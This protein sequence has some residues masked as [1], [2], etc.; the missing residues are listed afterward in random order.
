M[1]ALRTQ[2][3]LLL[4]TLTLMLLSSTGHSVIRDTDSHTPITTDTASSVHMK[5]YKAHLDLAKNMYRNT[6]ITTGNTKHISDSH[7]GNATYLS[8]VSSMCP[9]AI[10]F[11]RDQINSAMLPFNMTGVSEP[12]KGSTN[13]MYAQD[14][15]LG[16]VCKV[17]IF[18][19]PTTTL[20][21][22]V[23]YLLP[24]VAADDGSWG[25]FLTHGHVAINSDSR[26][27]LH[28]LVPV[29]YLDTKDYSLVYQN[30]PPLRIR[31]E[32]LQ[33]RLYIAKTSV[34]AG[35]VTMLHAEG[36][37][38]VCDQLKVPAG[39]VAIISFQR[40]PPEQCGI[41]V[42]LLC[43]D[44]HNSYRTVENFPGG[45][46]CVVKTCNGTQ[47][48][49][50]V[51][52]S[53]DYVSRESCF[54]LSFSFLPQGSLPETLSS[55][56]H[57]C[58]VADDT[59]RVDTGLCRGWVA[60]GQ[61][62]YKWFTSRD[63]YIKPEKARDLCRSM[64]FEL[65]LLKTMQGFQNFVKY[66]KPE[67]NIRSK[68]I[69]LVYK[70]DEIP[71]MYRHVLT[72]TDKTIIYNTNH[73]RMPKKRPLAKEYYY[74]SRQ[75]KDVLIVTTGAK[76]LKLKNF[77]CEKPVQLLKLS[78]SQSVE[79]PF[80][81]QSPL[82]SQQ[83]SQPVVLCTEGHVTLS[84]LSCDPKSRCGTTACSFALGT[85]SFSE[86]ISAALH[87]VD[88]VVMYAC[89]S[90]YREVSYSLLCDFRQ[91]CE[92][93]SDESF[94]YHP[95]C[96]GFSCPN[97][98]CLSL[99]KR[100]NK[101][102]DCLG[103]SDEDDCRLEQKWYDRDTTNQNQNTSYLI[104]FDGDG[105][106]T[107]RVMN[108][109]DPCPGTHYRCTKEWFYCLPVYTRCNGV[110]DCIF[111]EDERDCEGWTCPGLYRCRD[112]TVCVHADHMCDGWPVCPQH[113]DEWLCDMTCPT[114]CL[115][116]G[117]AFLC[118]QPFSAH[119]FPQLRYLDARGSGM[120]L[121][122]L[123]NN[124]YIVHLNLGHC[125][126]STLPAMTFPNLQFFDLSYNEI[127]SI[128]MN[129]FTALSNL[130]ILILK[131]NPLTSVTTNPSN[132]RQTLLRQIDLSE[133]HLSEFKSKMLP[134]SPGVKLL[135]IS[136]SITHSINTNL[137]L[138]VPFLREIDIRG[139]IVNDFPSDIFL[140]LKDLANVYSS[141]YR[142]CCEKIL[143]NIAPKP[144]CLAPKHYLSSC[145]DMLQSEVYR[146]NFWFVVVMASMTNLFC[147]ACH[148]VE[149][150]VQIPYTGPVVVFMASLLCADFCVGIYASVIAAAHETFS[151]QYVF[152]EDRWK[153]GVACKVAGFL[154]LLSREV[155]ILI[156][157]LLSL[158]HLT[159]V[160]F[161]ISTYRFSS[162]SAAV[163][164]GVTWIVGSLLA[165]VP[166]LPELS[167][168]AHYGHT[169]VCSLMLH[170]RRHL[171]YEHHFLHA[172]LIF[173]LFICLL[174]CVTLAIIY[175]ATP[176]NRVLIISSE[177]PGSTS[178]DV[179]MKI[180]VT[181]VAGWFSV[182]TASVLTLAGVTGIATNVFM[183]IMVLPLNAAVNPLLCLW[184]A[185]AYKR[186][187]KQEERL[188]RLLKSRR[189]CVSN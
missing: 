16:F 23:E 83:F 166:L 187:Q 11:Y 7:K 78:T 80:S 5:M 75:F 50:C 181:D 63:S 15:H 106:F 40:R 22:R 110:F 182:T 59:G 189:K 58:S 125:S 46:G 26:V 132:T 51:V 70:S 77:L 69:G 152:Y 14:K 109:T 56:R 21:A 143:P 120:A 47:L 76:Y 87:P 154:S 34:Y 156:I 12:P 3:F 121:F 140:G 43:S 88:H 185:V 114:Q 134:F 37:G 27:F 61:K 9:G 28:T 115:C 118:P 137:A 157:F 41:S 174:V 68:I 162:R 171:K 44:P 57:N 127:K 86:V 177:N 155:S 139:V 164:S 81:Q 108:I 173:N 136:Y 116:Q 1:D 147:L 17:V 145:D 188:L 149:T 66:L 45:Q 161:P 25:L 74:Y 64:G 167:H 105:F 71:S 151:G 10:E 42:S 13:W 112:S 35:F 18:V 60:A 159:L 135:N 148:C 146:F 133:T 8:E 95:T 111:Q 90:G 104:N 160:S 79:F 54:K 168:L 89:S 98:Q 158:N 102:V 180:A 122:Y 39:H 131:G 124:T 99:N 100:C 72:W 153:D 62:C 186:R 49:V 142:F 30:K 73:V 52:M 128:V 85:Q 178:V 107:Q 129:I 48:D 6:E 67:T 179:I 92:D 172:I 93:N 184:H 97:G 119:L 4:A 165:S 183:V 24:S 144:R 94:C 33:G 29:F 170:D 101:V 36:M 82:T 84:F 38:T 163:A 2:T 91:D 175:T 150:C 169:A 130:Q 141:D 113:D 53:P 176:R 20:R 32:V 96:K 31:F 123:S 65:T 117:H 103:G 55:P 19:P 138:T 126:I